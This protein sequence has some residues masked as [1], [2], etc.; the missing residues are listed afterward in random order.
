M[1][2]KS[3]GHVSQKQI[4]ELEGKFLIEL[5]KDYKNFLMSTDGGILK[6]DE[7]NKILVPDAN[8]VIA[9]LVMYGI[10]VKEEAANIFYWMDQYGE[11]ISDKML[12]IG[13]STAHGFFVIDC[14]EDGSV[15]FWDDSYTF[16]CSNDSCNTY[17]IADSFTDFLKI[18]NN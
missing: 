10:N 15:Y 2:I 14:G 6:L 4:E 17:W 5:P 18:L 1:E 11:E 9:V 13:D 3:H 7:S 12:I 8:E 16:D